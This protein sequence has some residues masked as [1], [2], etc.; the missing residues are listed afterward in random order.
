VKLEPV[1]APSIQNL[2]LFATS[3]GLH[4]DDDELS[5][6]NVSIKIEDTTAASHAPSA[7]PKR[8]V[9]KIEGVK[10]EKQEERE[11]IASVRCRSKDMQSIWGS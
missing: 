1:E 4:D 11:Y 10:V 9:I 8:N 7:P 5:K 3:Y 2:H 6:S